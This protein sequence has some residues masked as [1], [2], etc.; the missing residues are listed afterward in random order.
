VT[1]GPRRPDAPRA[2]LLMG[3]ATSGD[4][5][6]HN[7]PEHWALL[8]GMLRTADLAAAVITDDLAD[9]TPA[10]LARFDVLLNFSTDLVGTDEQMDALLGAVEA[11]AGF[12]GLHAANATFRAS[13]TYAAMVG[14]RFARHPPIKTFTVEIVDRDHP[15][16]AGLDSFEVEDERYELKDE[17]PDLRVLARAEG[18]TSIYVRQHGRGRVCYVAP[19][20]DRRTLELP[21]YARLVHQAIAW[22]AGMEPSAAG[23]E[24]RPE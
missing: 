4:R 23:G 6:F 14:S 1:V 18:H 5:Q 7:Q 13:D 10:N 22:T 12:V 11:G 20:H 15:V 16:T 3:Q 9:L 2:L 19:G 21:Q 24:G 17:A 8:A